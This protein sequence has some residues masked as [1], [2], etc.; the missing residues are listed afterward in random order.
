MKIRCRLKNIKLASFFI[1]RNNIKKW[2]MLLVEVE[3]N[4]QTRRKCIVLY[5][6]TNYTICGHI[7]GHESHEC[8]FRFRK[9]RPGGYMRQGPWVYAFGFRLNIF[10]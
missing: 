7:V 8:T 5:M 6:Y 2:E 9:L 10:F 3:T 4:H 1:R